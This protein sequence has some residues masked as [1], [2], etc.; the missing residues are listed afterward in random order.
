MNIIEKCKELPEHMEE[1]C[2]KDIDEAM[3]NGRRRL[4]EVLNEVEFKGELPEEK[5]KHDKI[6]SNGVTNV[7]TKRNRSENQ[8]RSFLEDYLR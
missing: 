3:E 8:R 1:N 7:E 6:K 5:N 2:V 4:I